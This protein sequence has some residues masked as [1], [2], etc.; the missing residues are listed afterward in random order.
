MKEGL[1]AQITQIIGTL[2]DLCVRHRPRPP[3]T[4]HQAESESLRLSYESKQYM[5]LRD[6][7]S[8]SFFLMF[9]HQIYS[10]RRI[11]MGEREKDPIK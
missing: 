7:G 10:A 5:T 1:F 3:P 6:S 9:W 8:W 11:H 2:L 4:E